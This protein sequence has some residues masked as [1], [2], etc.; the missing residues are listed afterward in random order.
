M[1][2]IHLLSLSFSCYSSITLH[3]SIHSLSIINIFCSVFLCPNKST[4]WCLILTGLI[5]SSIR[6]YEFLITYW[7]HSPDIHLLK[8]SKVLV[9]SWIYRGIFCHLVII[10]Q[11][12][13]FY[14]LWVKNIMSC[15]KRFCQIE[16]QCFICS[17]V[18]RI[19]IMNKVF[20]DN[21][22]NFSNIWI[23]P[24]VKVNQSLKN[25]VREYNS[26]YSKWLSNFIYVLDFRN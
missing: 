4:E 12:F 10:E 14:I 16:L 15:N 2:I 1:K 6:F 25:V 19:V 23:V 11:C 24:V 20:C 13:S 7:K 8:P 5:K 17:C 3:F 21:S 9:S 18:L 22:K 26:S